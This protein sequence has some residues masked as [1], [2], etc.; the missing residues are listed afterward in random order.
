MPAEN[1]FVCFCLI[2]RFCVLLL[3]LPGG[4]QKQTFQKYGSQGQSLEA[5]Q[6]PLEVKDPKDPLDRHAAIIPQ[7]ELNAYDALNALTMECDAFVEGDLLVT[8]PQ[9]KDAEGCH[10]ADVVCLVVWLWQLL[11][12]QVEKLATLKSNKWQEHLRV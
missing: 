8:F 7:F 6:R 9:C 5:A 4:D 2:L 1:V 10:L 3:D 11:G 12:E